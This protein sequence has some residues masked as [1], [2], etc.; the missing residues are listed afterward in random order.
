VTL[1]QAL[2]P[3]FNR[4][5]PFPE[6]GFIYW[7]DQTPIDTVYFNSVPQ[8]LSS[9]ASLVKLL[10]KDSLLMT[11]DVVGN[12]TVYNTADMQRIYTSL[13]IGAMDA[14]LLDGSNLLVCRSAMI[15]NSPFLKVNFKN[16]ETVPVPYPVS[17]GTGVGVDSTGKI[18]AAGI[19]SGRTSSETL[20]LELNTT[21]TAYSRV[22]DALPQED[23]DLSIAAAANGTIACNIGG[24]ET[25]LY[26]GQ[27]A[28]QLLPRSPGLPL[29]IENTD[30]YF[31]VLDTLGC[32]TW[33]QA[34]TGN[35]YGTLSFTPTAWT[36]TTQ[37]TKITG[38]LR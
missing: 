5:S 37:E 35:L 24:E 21:N 13:F 20:L 3:G 28:P 36:F 31:I 6:N 15:E 23:T 14:A 11:L 7:S 17:I 25:R 19:K 34:T 2:A 33:Y 4:V 9:R 32:I 29:R 27:A 38:A 10:V 12:V 16:G 22:L 1:E 8:K 18:Y 30:E 26:Q